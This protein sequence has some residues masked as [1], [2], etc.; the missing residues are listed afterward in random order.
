MNAGRKIN[1][2]PL[3]IVCVNEQSGVF[4]VDSAIP[5]TLYTFPVL[6]LVSPR[7]LLSLLSFTRKGGIAWLSI[8][9]NPDR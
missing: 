2:E 8:L 6:F 9:K 4:M 5:E 1:D 3:I 7:W